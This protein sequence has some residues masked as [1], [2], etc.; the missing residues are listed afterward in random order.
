M[1]SAVGST[2][3]SAARSGR[4]TTSSKPAGAIFLAI[5]A[6]SAWVGGTT[7]I[8]GGMAG[9]V[10]AGGRGYRSAADVSPSKLAC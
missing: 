5:S 1:Y 7:T 6:I 3:S 4:E 9:P 2:C 8:L 10:Q